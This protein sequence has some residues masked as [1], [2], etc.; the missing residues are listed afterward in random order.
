VEL[1][2]LHA[3]PLDGSMWTGQQG[4]LPGAT[5]APTL[6]GFGNNVEVWAAEALRL[7][8][9]DRLIVVGC[10]V[11]GS[12]AVE[13][14]LAAPDRIAALV[15][16]G[17]KVGHRPEPNLHASALQLVREEG[18]GKAWSLYWEPLFSKSSDAA[19]IARAKSIA[20]RQTPENVAK[21]ITAFHTRKARDGYLARLPFPIAVV[22]G[23]EDVAPGLKTSALQAELARYGRLHVIP[24]C[25]HYV[26]MERPEALNTILKDVIASEHA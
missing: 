7:V 16:I 26:P 11:G 20:L 4:L 24:D 8:K 21:G 18:L 9:S 19:L 12:C 2:F 14:A 15:L 5:H 23:A 10:S 22:T 3:L 25:G 6:Y 17:T 1:L 13:V